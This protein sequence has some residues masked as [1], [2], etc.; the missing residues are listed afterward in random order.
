MVSFFFHMGSHTIMVQY[1]L[2]Q[3]SSWST[4]LIHLSWPLSRGRPS[5]LL[6]SF[7]K[8]IL[9]Y[10]GPPSISLFVPKT[11]VLHSTASL[12]IGGLALVYK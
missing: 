3:P 7:P 1:I 6:A 9:V 12:L 11:H 4:L 8:Y 2:E 5:L 10:S